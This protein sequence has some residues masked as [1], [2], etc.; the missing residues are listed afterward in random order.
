[1]SFVNTIQHIPIFPVRF[2]DNDQKKFSH[3]RND[4]SAQKPIIL[5]KQPNLCLKLNFEQNTQKTSGFGFFL[6]K[7]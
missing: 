7:T 6:K 2:T 1:M 4:F 5:K 3:I